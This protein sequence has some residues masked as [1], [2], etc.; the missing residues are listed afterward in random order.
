MLNTFNDF[1][2]VSEFYTDSPY[3][4]LQPLRHVRLRKLAPREIKWLLKFTQPISVREL[5]IY[6]PTWL[7]NLQMGYA[8]LVEH[9][10]RVI[11]DWNLEK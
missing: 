7:V 5:A 11:W 6:L 4:F 3:I 10:G 2:C 1:G 8:M 9:T